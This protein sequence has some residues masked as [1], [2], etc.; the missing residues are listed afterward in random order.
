M[1]SITPAGGYQLVYLATAA[2]ARPGAAA[3][4]ATG[5]DDA[6]ADGYTCPYGYPRGDSLFQFL[7]FKFQAFH[8]IPSSFMLKSTFSLFTRRQTSDSKLNHPLT[9]LSFLKL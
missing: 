1:S 9:S 4:T 5:D 2:A 6:N 3:V 8:E 7:D